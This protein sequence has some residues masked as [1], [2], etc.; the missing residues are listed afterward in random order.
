MTRPAAA[1]HLTVVVCFRDEQEYLPVF[2][3]S[4]AAQTRPADQIVLVD[5]G[6]A[7][8]SAELADAF[9][10]GHEHVRVV[11]RPRRTDGGDRLAQAAEL[12]AFQEA[13]R[14][15]PGD[16][17]VVAKLDADLDLAPAT[18]ATIIDALAADP[19][20]GLAGA[21]LSELAEDGTPEPMMSPPEHVEGATKFYRRACWEQIAPLPEILGWDTLD[22]FHA[23][24]H[25]WRT[26]S[27]VVPGGDPI[28][29]RRMGTHGPILR[30]FRRWGACSWGYGADPLYVAFYGLRL[31]RRRRPRVVGG[32]NYYAG[33]AGAA[34]RRAPRAA[35]ELRR[36]LRREQR[37]KARRRLGRA[38]P[39]R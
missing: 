1:E 33:W 39:A 9:A 19:R 4:L 5:D 20:L 25:G 2:L 10:A 22:E 16:W 34:L 13:V 28:H 18:F 24:L 11:R 8:A 12:R 15:V 26:R 14:A 6:S 31:M 27:F 7:D 36:A 32:L 3:R 17:S 38:L 37:E 29:L 30:S 35:P 23:R 21:R